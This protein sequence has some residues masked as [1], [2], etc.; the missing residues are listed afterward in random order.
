MERPTFISVIGNRAFR[1][2][3]I[4]Q[5]LIQLAFNTLN[6]TL[7][8]WVFK[9]TDSNL[10]VSVLMI[11]IYLPALIFGLL[12]GIFVDI[13]DRK[14]IILTIDFLFALAFLFFIVIK[15]FYPLLLLNTFF[16]NSLGQFFMPIESSSIPMLVKRR[17]LLLANSLF[18]IT[19]Y[20]SFM[21][22]FSLAGPILSIF[23]INAIFYLGFVCLSLA[24]LL[25]QNLPS[26]KISQ[27]KKQ[28]SLHL[29]TNFSSIVK[30]A[31]TETRQTLS[32]IRGKISVAT[33][34]GLLAGA[35]GVIGV[36]AVLISA[37]ME[38]VLHIHATDASYVVM[39]PLGLG[40]IS[41]AYF[42]GKFAHGIPRRAIVIP[43]LILVGILF[44]LVALVPTI[45]HLIQ[46]ADLPN[47]I[48]HPRFFF[49]APSLS[50][51][52][53]LG[54]FLMGICAVGVIVPAQTVLQENTQEQIRGKIF[55]VVGVAMNLFAA[56]PVMLAGGLSDLFGE[57][58]IFL[59]MGMMI[60]ATGLLALKP[61]FFFKENHLPYRM[62]EFLGLGHWEEK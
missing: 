2:L 37:Y 16:V 57:T 53:A 46:A 48:R 50:L 20:G 5:I 44:M 13:A 30:L 15:K 23:G 1:F 26:I 11:S 27:G 49:R 40:M 17:Q 60:F 10:A 52:Y 43:C 14:K 54:A 9:L 7:I 21:I 33:S 19:L 35:Q 38:R 47:H 32:A 39:V 61:G 41:G 58:P 18:S 3:W 34:I 22:G 55:G 62:R 6:F 59:V 51:I 36:L 31:T 24:W 45:A 56:V 29:L 12:A 42:I 25:S 8:I 4:N 28:E